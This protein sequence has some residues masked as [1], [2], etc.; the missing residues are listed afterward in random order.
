MKKRKPSPSNHHRRAQTSSAHGSSSSEKKQQEKHLTT[1]FNTMKYFLIFLSTLSIGF[2]FY[3]R[4]TA[5][6]ELA[7]TN[8]PPQVLMETKLPKIPPTNQPKPQKNISTASVQQPPR[9]GVPVSTS[10]ETTLPL[11]DKVSPPTVSPTNQAPAPKQ[12]FDVVAKRIDRPGH[13]S[14]S[15][16]SN[17]QSRVRPVAQASPSRTNA[18][19]RTMLSD[20]EIRRLPEEHGSPPKPNLKEKAISYDLSLPAASYEWPCIHSENCPGTALCDFA[21]GNC[22]PRIWQKRPEINDDAPEKP[23]ISL[24][25][26]LRVSPGDF[27]LVDGN[28]VYKNALDKQLVWKRGKW[29]VLDQM[30]ILSRIFIGDTPIP[31]E[32]IINADENRLAIKVG[33]GMSGTVKIVDDELNLTAEYPHP[34]ELVSRKRV[35]QKC[36]ADNPPARGIPGASPDLPGPF[37]AGFVDVH[38]PDPYTRVYYPASCGGMRTPPVSGAFPVVFFL[39]GNGANHINYEYLAHFLASWGFLCVVPQEIDPGILHQVL[40]TALRAPQNFWSPLRGHSAGGKAFVIAHSRGGERMENLI[41]GPSAS[42]FLAIVNLAP[43][44]PLKVLSIPSMYFASSGDRQAFSDSL[45][46]QW[47]KQ[48]S[49]TY[50]LFLHGGNHSQFTD[51]RH[52]E[53]YEDQ[54]AIPFMPRKRQHSLVQAYTLAFFNSLLPEPGS[55]P[56]VELLDGMNMPNDII[57]ESR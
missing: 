24:V 55:R 40:M 12:V 38:S 36:A 47:S 22:E 52:W 25:K 33:P 7:P 49:P 13:N 56:Y 32:N 15:F 43:Y 4:N 19:R 5:E 34:V 3:K 2:Y 8:Q 9:N 46:I 42:R 11:V 44:R 18:Q 23:Q 21:T 16:F 6:V 26:P 14:S 31:E 28:S 48:P 45:Y 57:L 54:D 27:L 17:K 51:T 10:S 35:V 30:I 1:F 41:V 39:H 53:K 20:Q 37:A 50:F 29:V